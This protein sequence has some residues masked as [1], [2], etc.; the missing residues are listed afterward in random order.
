ME[1]LKDIWA[2]FRDESFVL[3]YLSPHLIRKL[4]LF[5][6]VDDEVEEEIEV[7]AIHDERG[8]KKVRRALSRQYDAGRMDPNIQVTS[9]D[10]AGD[11]MLELTHYV[12]E[13]VLLNDD[14]TWKVLRHLSNLWGYA[15]RLKEVDPD[16][17]VLEEYEIE[18]E[19]P[20]G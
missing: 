7:A 18:A 15:V 4:G 3:Q 9:V 17:L 2:N 14:D 1:V 11:R 16:G 12:S 19:D 8:Y 13:G 10:L 5:H 20:F 6:I